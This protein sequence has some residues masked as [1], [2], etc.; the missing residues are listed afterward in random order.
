MVVG[1]GQDGCRS[2]LHQHFPDP[3]L[4]GPT[5]AAARQGVSLFIIRLSRR[6]QQQNLAS[7]NCRT[8]KIIAENPYFP[9][10]FHASG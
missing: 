9:S 1:T 8:K 2:S 6:D 4:F 5:L 7:C 10:L 3:P